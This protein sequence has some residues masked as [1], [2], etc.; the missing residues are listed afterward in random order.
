MDG[1]HTPGPWKAHA[2]FVTAEQ[3]VFGVNRDRVHSGDVCHCEGEGRHT[4]DVQADMRL[5]AA[6][7]TLLAVLERIVSQYP[8][9]ISPDL[10]CSEMV[11]QARAA[12]ALARGP[13]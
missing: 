6:A 7:P 1:K 5:I 3:M 2:S 4:Y 9:P 11:I 10:S 12:I 8:D 13:A